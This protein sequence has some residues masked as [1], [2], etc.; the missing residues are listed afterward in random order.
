[1]SEHAFPRDV[2]HERLNY[3]ERFYFGQPRIPSTYLDGDDYIFG[4][5]E[6]L[7][8]AIQTV[9]AKNPG[10]LAIVN[11]P[12]A[13]LIGEDLHQRLA[14]AATSIP[15]VTIEMPALSQPMA[16]GYQQ[17]ILTVLETLDLS[18]SPVCPKAV[19]LIGISIAHHH[20][21]GSLQELRHLL[22]LCGI[23][24]LCA[25]GA[26]SATAEW[27][28]IPRAACHVVV[29][30]EYAD[31]IAAW[32]TKRFEAP[33]VFPESGAP[34]GF[35]ATEQWVI[36]VTRAVGAD[37]SAAL[38][39]IRDR[40]R[41]VSCHMSRISGIGGALKGMACSI[42][43][44]PSIALPLARFLYD[45][46]GMLPVSVATPNYV[47]THLAEQLKDFLSR[48]DCLDAWQVPWQTVEADFL[49]S[50]G[51]QVNQRQAFGCPEWG[52]ELLLP[53]GGE[54]DFIRKPFLG[55]EG[56]AYLVERIV[57]A[58]SDCL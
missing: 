38:A 15:G 24:V 34:V 4:A 55:A 3:A 52:I 14:D 39:D 43:A 21:A 17:A 11:S 46:L 42:Q 37:P 31:R 12:S 5:K 8:Q 41:Q 44:E 32:L 33:V 49:F 50:D 57:N 27:Y 58:V 2:T 28:S 16:D 18:R 56:A 1:M 20:W 35:E 25:P 53:L 30:A 13:A 45:Y 54:V 6:K 36:E 29:H 23:E 51:H 10:L 47:H 19:S 26:G 40:R 22:A 7:D 9:L 48:V